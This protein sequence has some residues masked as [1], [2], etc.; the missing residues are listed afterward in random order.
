MPIKN[1]K[2]EME[3][4]THTPSLTKLSKKSLIDVHEL[5]KGKLSDKTVEYVSKMEDQLI[6]LSNELKVLTAVVEDS[7]SEML[8]E[9][10]ILEIEKNQNKTRFGL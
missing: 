9:L 5:E 7:N 10:R 3:K 4:S 2:I 1:T 6:V 8:R